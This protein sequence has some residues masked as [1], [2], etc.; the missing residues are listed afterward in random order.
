MLPHREALGLGARL[1]EGICWLARAERQR[2][3]ANLRSS[4]TDKSPKEIEG[5]AQACFRNLGKSLVEVMRFS[6]LTRESVNRLVTM[7]GQEALDDA[8]ARKRGVILLTG[9]FGNWE[10]MGARL[11][12]NG[13]PLM[14]IARRLRSARLNQL[15]C[16]QRQQVV[17]QILF[18]GDSI[19]RGIRFLRQNGILAILADV[20]TATPGVFVEFFGRPAYTPYGPVALA[21]RTQAALMPMFIIRRPDDS[22][23]IL[24]HPPLELV[25]TGQWDS[26]LYQNTQRFTR[27]FETTIRRYPEQWIWMHPRWKTRPATPGTAGLGVRVRSVPSAG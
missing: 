20:D 1:G 3:I 21:L 9:H 23:H 22:H 6:R 5:I 19:R 7:E 16:E 14:V 25:S 12:L 8:L 24:I 11:T 15:L 18:R 26:D 2:A 13:Y 17:M 4:L 10:L 27:L